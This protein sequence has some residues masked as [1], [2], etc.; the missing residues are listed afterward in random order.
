MTSIESVGRMTSR[1]FF[2]VSAVMEIGAGLVLLIAPA[3]AIRLVLGFSGIEAGVAI[4]R[5]AGAAL[6]SLGAGCWWARHDG[7]SSASRALVSGMLIYNAVVAVLVLSASL[8]SLGPLLLALALLHGAMALWS[9]LS[10]R[11]GP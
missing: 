11:I 6:L 10:L 2:V 7:G 9:L 8:G 5:V 1:Q 4:G 3:L